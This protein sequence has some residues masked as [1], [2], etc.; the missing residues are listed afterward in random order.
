MN[1]IRKI[2]KKSKKAIDLYNKANKIV[3]DN[4]K[5]F[6]DS[7]S[8]EDLKRMLQISKER[9]EQFREIQLNVII[10]N[11]QNGILSQTDFENFLE[12]E[13]CYHYYLDDN[14][15]FQELFIEALEN[16]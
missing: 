14:K 3:A 12:M 16:L 7:V 8:E 2:R 9:N 5:L 4:Q 13:D 6:Y 11:R 15:S 1:D 10:Q